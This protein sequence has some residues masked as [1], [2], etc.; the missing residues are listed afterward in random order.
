MQRA[1]K[2]P[3]LKPFSVNSAYVRTFA[4]VSKSSGASEFCSQVF[5]YMTWADNAAALKDIKEAFKETE[6]CLKFE[7]TAFYTPEIYFTKKSILSNRTVDQ[8]NWEKIL[9]DCLCLPK[10]NE[11]PFPQGAPNICADDR[12]VSYSPSAKLPSLKAG[13][14]VVIT[15][16]PKP[17]IVESW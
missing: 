14:K 17:E 8:T 1:L 2:F 7:L 10:F 3:G 4:G 12:F 9:L 16:L 11:L 13:I 6:H 5:N 15:I